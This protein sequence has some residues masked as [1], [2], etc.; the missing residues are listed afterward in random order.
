MAG[1]QPTFMQRRLAR[2][3]GGTEMSRLA[4]S[5]QDQIEGITGE[6]ETKFSEYKK[7]VADKMAPFEQAVGQYDS[8]LSAY[9][10]Q[11]AS[12][13][14]AFAGYSTR[15]DQFN[16]KARNYASNPTAFNVRIG[17]ASYIEPGTGRKLYGAVNLD[18][19][20]DIYSYLKGQGIDIPSGAGYFEVGTALTD[21]KKREVVYKFEKP[22]TETFTEQAP[23]APSAF[24]EAAP[25]A[26]VIEKFDESPFSAKRSQL[27]SDM[28]RE[29]SERKSSRMNA[30]QRGRGRPLLQGA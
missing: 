25:V 13:N 20:Q 21:K 6:Y 10:G 30:A 2:R 17:D 15:L 16:Q 18:T 8:K 1:P 22:F 7:M 26:P 4:K 5:Y 14:D 27:Q 19:G 11:V 12:F 28:T 3:V 23:A 24:T 29:V 9:Q